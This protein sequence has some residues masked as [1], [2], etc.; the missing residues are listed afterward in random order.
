MDK[1]N[2]G[3]HQVTFFEKIF[4]ITHDWRYLDAVQMAYYSYRV[5]S[6][7]D[8]GVKYIKRKCSICNRTEKLDHNDNWL[9][10]PDFDN[11]CLVDKRWYEQLQREHNE[12]EKIKRDTK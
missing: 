8:S 10:V 2:L 7:F 1:D 3:K 5:G 4:G 12:L 9:P 11:S 6:S